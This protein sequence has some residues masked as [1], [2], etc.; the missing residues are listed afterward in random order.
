MSTD[1]NVN[2]AKIDIEREIKDSKERLTIA[3]RGETENI[4]TEAK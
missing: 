4:E 1:D 3:A 2:L